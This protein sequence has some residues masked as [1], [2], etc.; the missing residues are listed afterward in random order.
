MVCWFLHYSD[1][2]DYSFPCCINIFLKQFFFDVTKTAQ[3][4]FELNFLLRTDNDVDE[5]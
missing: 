5:S 1:S 2:I 4:D 3:K